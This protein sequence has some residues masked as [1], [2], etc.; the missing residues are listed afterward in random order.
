MAVIKRQNRSNWNVFIC[1]IRNYKARE[2]EARVICDDVGALHVPSLRLYSA[3]KIWSTKAGFLADFFMKQHL[4]HQ[5]GKLVLS[6][7]VA[8]LP[9]VSALAQ[10][11]YGNILVNNSMPPPSLRQPGWEAGV[12]SGYVTAV[13]RNFKAS[14]TVIQRPSTSISRPA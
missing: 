6:G 14:G 5:L 10:E 7:A 11:D 12:N 2:I 8:T 13:R 3:R 1:L 4:T 9:V